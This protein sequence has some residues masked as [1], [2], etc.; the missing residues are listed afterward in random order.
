MPAPARSIRDSV[1]KPPSATVRKSRASRRRALRSRI[2]GGPPGP[3]VATGGSDSVPAQS[4]IDPT[5]RRRVEERRSRIIEDL[6][7]LLQGEILCD[8]LTVSMYS[9]DGSLY[10]IRPLG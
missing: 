4:P 1:S 6:T 7:P 8:P 5:T 2:N 10:Q 9:T 3:P